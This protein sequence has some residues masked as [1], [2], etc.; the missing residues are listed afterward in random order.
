[1]RVPGMG[2]PRA[3]IGAALDHI[4]AAGI[5]VESVSRVLT[6]DPIGPSQRRY[7]N[8]AAILGSTRAPGDLLAL[9]Q[10]IE[11]SFGRRRRGQRWR[12]RPLDIDLILWSGGVFVSDRLT[13]PHPA[14]RTRHFVLDPAAEIAPNW[15]DPLTGRTLRQLSTRLTAPRPLPRARNTNC[16]NTARVGP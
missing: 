8:A 1:M 7:A 10:D 11:T 6:T 15:R 3:V 9:T 4:A 16:A 14:F 2:G 12:A 13:I 5:A